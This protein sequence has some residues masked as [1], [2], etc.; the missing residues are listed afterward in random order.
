MSEKKL[1][2]PTDKVT[3]WHLDPDCGYATQ[4]NELVP[5]PD[6]DIPKK[7]VPCSNCAGGLRAG[8]IRAVV[9]KDE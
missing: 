8:K 5:V 6:G 3:T 4:A 7:A 1:V 9:R 2:A